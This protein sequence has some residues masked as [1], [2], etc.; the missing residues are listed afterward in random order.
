MSCWVSWWE[1]TTI[2]ALQ[3]S[4]IPGWDFY[5]GATGSRNSAWIWALVAV[6]PFPFPLLQSPPQSPLDVPKVRPDK[7]SRDMTHDAGGARCLSFSPWRNCRPGEPGGGVMLSECGC[8]SH[9]SNVVHPGLCGAAGCI[10]LTPL[11][12]GFHSGVMS[13]DGYCSVFLWRGLKLGMTCVSILMMSLLHKL[14]FHF[15]SSRL[16]QNFGWLS[17]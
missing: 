5:L 17:I 9:F 15:Y 4:K 11:S 1:S 7:V 13:V 12:Q 10:I 2:L 6:S 3:T 16:V 8:F 14:L